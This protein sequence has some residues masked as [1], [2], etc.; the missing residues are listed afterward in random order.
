MFESLKD[1]QYRHPERSEGSG[2]ICE[3][4]LFY[5]MSLDSPFLCVH[6]SHAMKYGGY[7]YILT[8]TSHTVLYIGVTANLERRLEQ[9]KCQAV[10]GFT[11]KYK[12]HKLVYYE[13]HDR[14]EDAIVREKQLK[15]KTRAK[16][17]ALITS[18]NPFWQELSQTGDPSLRSG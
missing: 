16:K 14:I 13:R 15:G 1:Q 3:V 18:I 4:P 10:P 17:I 9:H 11:S 7:T 8:N 12:V 2:S 5:W 6:R